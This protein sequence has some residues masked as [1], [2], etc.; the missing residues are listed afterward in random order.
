MHSDGA[1]VV[2]MRFK[3]RNFLRG[4]VVVYSQL[5][6]IG[7]ANDPILSRNETSG[8]DGD[9]CEFEGFDNRLDKKSIRNERKKCDCQSSTWVNLPESHT[10]IYRHGLY[11]PRQSNTW[12]I[13]N[14]TSEF[15]HTAV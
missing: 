9:I 11:V 7:A 6:I 14:T 1:N 4:V 15:K 5:K 3:R 8:S 13:L 2:R 10:T 12:L